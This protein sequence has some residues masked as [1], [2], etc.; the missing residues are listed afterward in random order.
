MQDSCVT[1]YEA[2]FMGKVNQGLSVSI[3]L[4]FTLGFSTQGECRKLLLA[5]YSMMTGSS[6]S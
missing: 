1:V 4:V 5:L 2:L 3:F 6:A